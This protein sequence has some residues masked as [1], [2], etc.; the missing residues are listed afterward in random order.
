MNEVEIQSEDGLP[1]FFDEEGDEYVHAGDFRDV[2]SI[3]K[4]VDQQL[5]KF[6]LELYIGDIG[7]PDYFICVKERIQEM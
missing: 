3:L 1:R 5:A 2:D 4:T 7:S 6:D